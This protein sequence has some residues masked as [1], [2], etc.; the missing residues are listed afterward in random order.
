M[1][2]RLSDWCHYSGRLSDPSG[3]ELEAL[4]YELGVHLV[5]LS[6]GPIH[7]ELKPSSKQPWTAKPLQSPRAAKW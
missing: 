7:H 6:K 3:P 4:L 1:W 2:S 5:A